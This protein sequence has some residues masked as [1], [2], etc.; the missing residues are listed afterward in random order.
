MIFVQR[1]VFIF[2]PGTRE[3]TPPPP[4]TASPTPSP[5]TPSPTPSPTASPTPSPTPPPTF[6]RHGNFE[7]FRW[8]YDMPNNPGAHS[9]CNGEFDS[10]LGEQQSDSGVSKCATR[11]DAVNNWNWAACRGFILHSGGNCY[12]AV[13]SLNTAR[14]RSGECSSLSLSSACSWTGGGTKTAYQ[15]VR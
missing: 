3:P 1:L 13:C 4:P 9:N 11:C 2:S 12:L 15:R 8:D 10:D 5:T 6:Q 14:R 7:K